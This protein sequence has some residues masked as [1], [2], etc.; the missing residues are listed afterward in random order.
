MAKKRKR[1]FIPLH[2]IVSY[3]LPSTLLEE[4]ERLKEERE[5]LLKIIANL[6]TRRLQELKEEST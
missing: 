5:Y 3:P 6:Q 4:I 1:I 2:P